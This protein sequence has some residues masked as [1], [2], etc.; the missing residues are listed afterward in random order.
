MVSSI[1]ITVSKCVKHLLCAR[2]PGLPGQME[3]VRG[4]AL[5]WGGVPPGLD[6]QLSPPPADGP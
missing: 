4:A 5:P 6:S 3:E 1:I 2:D